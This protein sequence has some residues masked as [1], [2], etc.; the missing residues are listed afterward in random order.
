[1]LK[2]S[3]IIKPVNSDVKEDKTESS[4]AKKISIQDEPS[5]ANFIKENFSNVEIFLKERNVVV[6][7]EDCYKTIEPDVTSPKI[8]NLKTRLKDRK[9]KF[10]SSLSD[11][12]STNNL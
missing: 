4:T 2:N 8:E 1:M 5:H 12:K 9:E 7:D 10:L 6:E 11:R 3:N